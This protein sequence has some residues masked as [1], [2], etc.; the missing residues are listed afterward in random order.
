MGT[1]QGD[2]NKAIIMPPGVTGQ[3]VVAG[4]AVEN[5]AKVGT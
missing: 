4:V 1:E 5:P 2:E 3:T